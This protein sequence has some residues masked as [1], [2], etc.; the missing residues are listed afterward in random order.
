MKDV[1]TGDKGRQMPEGLSSR[2]SCKSKKYIAVLSPTGG[3][4]SLRDLP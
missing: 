2:H 3:Y 4:A 1:E